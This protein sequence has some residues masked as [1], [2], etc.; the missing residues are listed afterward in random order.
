[1]LFF[2]PL[3]ITV[4]LW[5]AIVPLHQIWSWPLGLQHTAGHCLLKS[6]AMSKWEWART[7]HT[8]SHLGPQCSYWPLWPLETAIISNII[9]LRGWLHTYNHMHAI[10]CCIFETLVNDKDFKLIVHLCNNGAG[11]LFLQGAKMQNTDVL[12]NKPQLL[13]SLRPS[14][15]RQ[16]NTYTLY[17]A[18]RW[19]TACDI[20][21]YQSM[22]S[23]TNKHQ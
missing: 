2:I 9:T 4:Q 15:V 22:T 11:I 23:D 6:T 1:M 8:N 20:Q 18:N 5:H 21:F 16:T 10:L 14:Q 13:P 3:L 17:T 7:G 12:D 19:M